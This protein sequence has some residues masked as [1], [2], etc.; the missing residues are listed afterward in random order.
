VDNATQRSA[1]GWLILSAV[2]CVCPVAHVGGKMIVFLQKMTA[3]ETMQ[4][5]GGWLAGWLGLLRYLL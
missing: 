5:I 4:E 3:H 2:P 1:T